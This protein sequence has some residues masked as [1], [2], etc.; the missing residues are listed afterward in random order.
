MN[1]S[2]VS[3][4]KALARSSSANTYAR[5]LTASHNPVNIAEACC[6]LATWVAESRVSLSSGLQS[7]VMPAPLRS[8]VLGL[9][10]QNLPQDASGAF[11]PWAGISLCP[12][13]P[14]ERLTGTQGN[15]RSND[16]AYLSPFNHSGSQGSHL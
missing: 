11:S 8:V 1:A 2:H 15:V 3:L 13:I 12:F 7:I 16:S 5:T 9:A 10:T 4:S 6:E 14:V